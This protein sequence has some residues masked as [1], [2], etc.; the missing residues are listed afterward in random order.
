MD[1]ILCRPDKLLAAVKILLDRLTEAVLVSQRVTEPA[2]LVT[3]LNPQVANRSI[4]L[5]CAALAILAVKNAVPV[6]EVLCPAARQRKLTPNGGA[7]TCFIL[8]PVA[9]DTAVDV[10]VAAV[11]EMSVTV[12]LG[13]FRLR[14]FW[15]S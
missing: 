7:I 12:I 13:R 10:D 9:T 1:T 11:I 5:N 8:V 14:L 4:E 3:A 6:G 2:V 15:Y